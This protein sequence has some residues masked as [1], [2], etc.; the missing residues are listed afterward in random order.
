MSMT[1]M[2]WMVGAAEGASGVAGVEGSAGAGL[3]C[4]WAPAAVA[5]NMAAPAA[6]IVVLR[7]DCPFHR[8]ADDRFWVAR[9]AHTRNGIRSRRGSGHSVTMSWQKCEARPMLVAGGIADMTDRCI[10]ELKRREA[11]MSS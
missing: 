1:L 3:G 11:W 8:F 10:E 9:L 7:M 5:R 2:V 6:R 4:C